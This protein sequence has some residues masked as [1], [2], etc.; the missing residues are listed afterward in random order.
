MGLA[1]TFGASEYC[2]RNAIKPASW[3]VSIVQLDL[4]FI[5]GFARKTDAEIAMA[6]LNDTSVNWDGDQASVLADVVR[7][8]GG[9]R[10]NVM[11]HVCQYL[12][13]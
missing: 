11:K 3:R 8:F 5:E 1:V 2:K 7:E 9:S 4:F 6:V 12:Q 13:W 10:K